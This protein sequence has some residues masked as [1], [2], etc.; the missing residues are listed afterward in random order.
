MIYMPEE[1]SYIMKEELKKIIEKEKPKKV[2]DMGTGSGILALEATRMAK[3]ID[4]VDV[5]KAALN[6]V[7]EQ[8][9][10][11][12]FRNINVFYSDLFSNIKEKYDLIIFNPPYLPDGNDIKEK[13]LKQ[14]IIGGNKGNEIIIKFLKQAK[15]FLL[16][17]GKILF[18][19]SSLSNKEKIDEALRKENYEWK[20]LKKEKFWFEKLYVYLAWPK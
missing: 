1:D 7:K 3:H 19:F 12:G 18:C 8:I 4:A 11:L 17:K 20:L 14:A 9:A 6:F 2:L 16:P 5:N 10:K 15:D 13:W